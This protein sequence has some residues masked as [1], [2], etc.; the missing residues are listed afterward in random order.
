MYGEIFVI[1]YLA[2][3]QLVLMIPAFEGLYDD[4]ICSYK[5]CKLFKQNLKVQTYYCPD[6]QY[7]IMLV[8]QCL[9]RIMFM[10]RSGS[11]G[12]S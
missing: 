4:I 9:L 3:L 1:P 7:L 5:M 8:F 10:Q 6:T 11:I 12:R 2:C